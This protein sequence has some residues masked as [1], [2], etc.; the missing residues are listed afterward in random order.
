VSI[1]PLTE[2]QSHKEVNGPMDYSCICVSWW[3]CEIHFVRWFVRW[4]V[5][6]A[7]LTQPLFSGPSIYSAGQGSIATRCYNMVLQNPDYPR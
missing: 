1:W 5:L 6:G 3:L 4:M 7:R 2:T